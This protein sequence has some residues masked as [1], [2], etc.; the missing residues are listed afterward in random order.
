[1]VDYATLQLFCDAVGYEMRLDLASMVT[2]PQGPACHVSLLQVRFNL[3][4]RLL[5]CFFGRHFTYQV[6]IDC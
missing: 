1:M 6:G 4:L 5:E 2:S 3:C